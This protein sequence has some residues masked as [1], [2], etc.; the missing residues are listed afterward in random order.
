MIAGIGIDSVEI[1]RFAHWHSYAH[2]TLER[3]FS[4]HEIDYCLA[5]PSKNAERLAA[6]FAA[7]EA[8][9][10]A[11]C[12]YKSEIQIPFFTLCKHIHIEGAAH[13]V[14]HLVVDWNLLLKETLEEQI[15]PITHLSIT[16]NQTTAL[17]LVILEI[18]YKI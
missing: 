12:S 3:I 10:K 16:H 15:Y 17:A 2:T 13:A 14:Q 8:F 1:K 7:R 4:Q 5:V 6:R 9:Y 11:L 18:P